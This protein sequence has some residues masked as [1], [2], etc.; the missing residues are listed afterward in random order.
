MTKRILAPGEGLGKPGRPYNVIVSIKAYFA[1]KKDEAAN[2]LPEEN[3]KTKR[4]GKNPN[5]AEFHGDK[6]A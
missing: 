4:P 3:I 6:V 5:R 2:E 1:S